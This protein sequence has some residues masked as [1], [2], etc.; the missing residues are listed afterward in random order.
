M[1]ENNIIKQIEHLIALFE[2]GNA[3]DRRFF[4]D[5]EYA[6]FLKFLKNYLQSE[7]SDPADIELQIDALRTRIFK[8]EDNIEELIKNRQ[9]TPVYV[10]II[11]NLYILYETL[12]G[13]YKP[14]R[15]FLYN[16]WDFKKVLLDERKYG[17]PLMKR[18]LYL[19]VSR[20]NI[21]EREKD[22][23]GREKDVKAVL[24]SLVS[25]KKSSLCIS[26]IDTG[27]ENAGVGKTVLAKEVANLIT[28][29]TE[30]IEQIAYL[31]QT[32]GLSATLKTARSH[33]SDGVI[34]VSLQSY[35]K[36]ANIYLQIIADAIGEKY[37]SNDDTESDEVKS[38]DS[39]KGSQY[40]VENI[41]G[42]EDKTVASIE[43]GTRENIFEHVLPEERKASELSAAEK[44]RRAEEKRRLG[45]IRINSI[46]KLAFVL[47][48]RKILLVLDNAEQDRNT[49]GFLYARLRGFVAI[50]IT[51]RIRLAGIQTHLL[52]PFS[53]E[54]AKRYYY[55]FRKE[56]I[57]ELLY[58]D[59]LRQIFGL[60]KFN[61]YCLSILSHNLR[62]SIG[63]T[64]KTLREELK[65]T[66]EDTSTVR[67]I[68]AILEATKAISDDEKQLLFDA[69]IF[70]KE[71]FS[72]FELSCYDPVRQ[73]DS[74]QNDLQK[75]Y[76]EKRLLSIYS[77]NESGN[78]QYWM[79]QSVKQYLLEW[80]EHQEMQRENLESRNIEAL[81]DLLKQRISANE[82]LIDNA[83]SS[84]K[85]LNY[86]FENIRILN[87]LREALGNKKEWDK[88]YWADI[89]FEYFNKE[90][91]QKARYFQELAK[92]STTKHEDYFKYTDIHLYAINNE[93]F[94]AFV[95]ASGLFRAN[96][97]Q[98]AI[99]RFHGAIHD[100]VGDLFVDNYFITFIDYALSG[101][102]NKLFSWQDTGKNNRSVGY[103]LL[104]SIYMQRK[105]LYELLEFSI[106]KFI[107]YLSG[108]NDLAYRGL[109]K[110]FYLHKNEDLE[111]AEETLNILKKKAPEFYPNNWEA[112]FSVPESSWLLKNERYSEALES[113]D[114][115]AG[116]SA[117]KLLR[118]AE[119]YIGLNELDKAT[120]FIKKITRE[121]LKE[122]VISTQ[123]EVLYLYSF[124]ALQK[125]DL[126]HAALLLERTIAFKDLVD[127]ADLSR[128]MN[129]KH[130]I[131]A[132]AGGEASY[133]AF[134]AGKDLKP[135]F[136]LPA[137]I[138]LPNSIPDR[139]GKRM[140][141]IPLGRV[142]EENKPALLLD[143]V[144]FLTHI[145]RFLTT[146]Q[147]D[148]VEYFSR[149]TM[150]Y[151]FYV[152][153][154]PVTEARFKAFFQSLP[155]HERQESPDFNAENVLKYA[156]SMGKKPLTKQEWTKI[157][158]GVNYNHKS[159]NKILDPD[160]DEEL[161]LLC[162]KTIE[163]T[164]IES[165]F[166]EEIKQGVLG[167]FEYAAGNSYSEM[168]PC[169]P[170][171]LTLIAYAPVLG[172]VEKKWAVLRGLQN[173]PMEKEE[174]LFHLLVQDIENTFEIFA[175]NSEYMEMLMTSQKNIWK[176]ALRYFWGIEK[177]FQMIE[178]HG[179]P[180][181]VLLSKN[182]RYELV[183]KKPEKN[184]WALDFTTSAEAFIPFRCMKMWYE[185]V[186]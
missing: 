23:V 108:V 82:K 73:E 126:A 70:F 62:G 145:E 2:K 75:L 60:L 32:E 30:S 54:E 20:Q 21:P 7:S 137:F 100:T 81:R 107:G 142:I 168:L 143:E 1:E 156:E 164:V 112:E 45:H 28:A 80:F 44:A 98:N 38:N 40:S 111:M 149:E 104:L 103:S 74:V 57:A 96:S 31:N 148:M 124:L 34:W 115:I 131:V 95:K 138:N 179:N 120:E 63:E 135:H 71:Y 68:I 178:E 167:N 93:T 106:G 185:V 18:Q 184:L 25:E 114:R 122:R 6:L 110:L 90:R 163:D 176:I 105:D 46:E 141:R 140:K 56:Q 58:D 13:I 47:S 85:R 97:E 159:L 139:E 10:E 161:N 152:D 29:N 172:T 83:T 14:Q 175:E 53:F 113:A 61:P 64:D 130:K 92:V 127:L 118:I 119:A 26:G 89:V 22:F 186:Q 9:F 146:N 134:L 48:T 162:Q 77:E 174:A 17:Y 27:D 19:P 116:S 78:T 36:D 170:K 171:L 91:V 43:T 181:A 86:L 99:Y 183:E 102:V 69:S 5:P 79:H 129:L 4:D 52:P 88:E 67:I 94:N 150:L 39:N 101:I 128:E 35:K 65:K 49:F 154:E 84:D 72:A 37:L 132:R 147:I 16:L 33:F 165:P 42:G 158:K 121:N 87:Y 151:D 66:P 123:I 157:Y 155:E 117:K 169:H 160:Y 136:E 15:S 166:L 173:G 24:Q 144:F 182:G 41:D 3:N 12:V 180:E 51:C 133:Q 153:C 125:G 59:S 109:Q 55:N 8:F 177:P 76:G 50:L 11:D